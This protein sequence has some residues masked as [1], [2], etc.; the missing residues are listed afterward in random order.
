MFNDLV[1][2]IILGRAEVAVQSKYTQK[3]HNTNKND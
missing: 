1:T 3:I 2:G